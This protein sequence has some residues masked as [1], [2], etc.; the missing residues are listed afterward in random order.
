MQLEQYLVGLRLVGAGVAAMLAP[1][2]PIDGLR[3]WLASSVDDAKRRD[4]ARERAEAYS[5]YRF[6]QAA[7]RTAQRIARELG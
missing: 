2:A 6:D 5:T 4:A 3:E 1:E 7:A